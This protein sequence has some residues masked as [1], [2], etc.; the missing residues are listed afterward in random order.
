ML[1]YIEIFGVLLLK[2]AK[3]YFVGCS[4]SEL[5]LYSIWPMFILSLVDLNTKIAWGFWYLLCLPGILPSHCLTVPPPSAR[6]P[7]CGYP[8]PISSTVR[9]VVFFFRWRSAFVRNSWCY[10]CYSSSSP[11]VEGTRSSTPAPGKAFPPWLSSPPRRA[12]C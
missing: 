7:T 1:R 6:L 8:F 4:R 5:T 10:R 9:G 11:L 2:Q 3:R 12:S